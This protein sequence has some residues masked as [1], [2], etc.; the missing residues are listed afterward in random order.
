MQLNV[1]A[2]HLDFLCRFMA[3]NDVRFYLNGI[4]IERIRGGGALMIATDGYT[5][6][7]IRDETGQAPAKPTI[8]SITRP[9]LTASKKRV[10]GCGARR[11]VMRGD[12]LAVVNQLPDQD[13]NQAAE[14]YSQPGNPVVDGVFPDWRRVVPDPKDLDPGL[15]GEFNAEY[16]GRLNYGRYH[17]AAFWQGHRDTGAIARIT[18]PGLD[19]FVIIMPMRSGFGDD[20]NPLPDWFK[21]PKPKPKAKTTKGAKK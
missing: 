8:L 1:D 14:L 13:I 4:C 19:A 12:R 5:L 10:R 6:C 7:C 20:P 18:T 16:L 17:G 2:T 21:K 11:L 3:V 15:K 9:L